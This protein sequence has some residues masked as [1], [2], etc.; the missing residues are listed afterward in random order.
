VCL[1]DLRTRGE[2]VLAWLL[3]LLGRLDGTEGDDRGRAVILAYHRVLPRRQFTEFPLYED[4]VT[5]L[6]DFETQMAWLAR[7]TS[8][9]PLDQLF[10]ALRD[11]RRLPARTVGLTFDDGYADN[12][13]YAFPVLRRHRLP[14]TIFLATGHVG[15]ASGLFFWDEVARW[16]SAGVREIE[17]EGLGRRRVDLLSH[18]NRLIRDLKTYPVDEIAR[19]VRDAA[20]RVGVRSPRNAADDF[21]TWEQVREMQQGGIRFAAHTVSHCLLPR[22]APER[23]K[24]ELDESRSAIER[25]TGRP[26][27]LFCYPDGAATEE[28]A[29]EVEAAGFAGAVATGA[30]DVVPGA[31]LDLY[32]VPRKIVNYKA[33]MTAFRFRLSPHP[34]RI[35]RFASTRRKEQS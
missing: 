2:F 13:Q 11:D 34:E 20:A 14:A 3:R 32:R 28:V 33:G 17:I 5:P 9:L 15:G 12:Y 19:R 30:R 31:G 16:R 29:R 10:G 4:L 25:E 21:L 26:C 7:R 1:P 24:R 6:E 35:K 8:V 27:T 23:R 18:R 22:E